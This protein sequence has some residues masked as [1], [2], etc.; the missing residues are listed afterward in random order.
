MEAGIDFER[1]NAARMYDYFLGGAHNFA[2]DREFGDRVIAEM[3]VREWARGNRAFLAR[4]VRFCVE[5]GVRQFLDLGSG[6]PTVSHVHDVAREIAPETRVAYVDFE[7]VAVAHSEELLAH[8]DGV[9]ITRADAREPASV[10][11]AST[12]TE[13]LD[14]SDPVAVLA[15]ALMH[16]VSDDDDPEAMI[17]GY[18]RALVPGS[19]L[20]VTHGSADY[21][22]P[23][24][25]EQIF[26]ALEVYRGSATPA[27]LRDRSA[28][29]SLVAGLEL[30]E[31]GLVDINHWRNTETDVPPLGHYAAVARIP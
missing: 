26:G 5:Q 25:R 19:Y 24:L 10:L 18:R 20:A 22:D 17:A 23:A 6:I 29:R 11:A 14:F 2:V 4:V 27:V 1:A 16:F 30:V 21:D 13:V 15:V 31:P 7:P 3:P 9:S 28:I 12:V 8:V